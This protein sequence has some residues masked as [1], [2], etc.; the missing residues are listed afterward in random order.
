MSGVNKVILIG[1]LGVDPEMKYTQAGVPVT[2]FSIATTEL[3][4]KDEQGNNKKHTE[5]HKIVAW[6]KLG[7]ICSQYLSK[8]TKVY[9]EGRLRYN[10]FQDQDGIKRNW[11]EIYAD[12]MVILTPKGVREDVDVQEEE[13]RGQEAPEYEQNK[14]SFPGN[15]TENDS[16]KVDLDSDDIEDNFI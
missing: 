7:E 16:E 2:K 8:G 6:R 13:R 14:G 11:T 1:H 10:S 9:I 3:F 4:G 15:A 12:E 5:W